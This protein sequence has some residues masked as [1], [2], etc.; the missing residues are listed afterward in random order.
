M[1]AEFYLL[2]RSFS[3]QEG[4]TLD[5]LEDKIKSLDSDYTYIRNYKE[6]EKIYKHESIYSELIFNDLTVEDLLYYGRGK[7]LLEREDFLI[8]FHCSTF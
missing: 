2:N 7:G 4:L 3:Y 6:T 5:D 1:K 8:L